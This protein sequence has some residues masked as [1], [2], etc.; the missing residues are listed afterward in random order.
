MS[1]RIG[2]NRTRF[3][4]VEPAPFDPARHVALPDWGNPTQ[5]PGPSGERSDYRAGMDRMV[6]ALTDN[7]MEP[8]AATEQARACARRLHHRNT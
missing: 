8:R 6:K 4:D 3:E 1:D 7:G 2:W 5:N